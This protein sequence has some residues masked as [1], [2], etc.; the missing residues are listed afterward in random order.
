MRKIFCHSPALLEMYYK[1]FERDASKFFRAS[2]ITLEHMD[3][4]FT[5]KGE[6][7]KVIGQVDFKE[8]VCKNVESGSIY[9]IDRI[10]VQRALIGETNIDFT[11]KRNLKPLA[12]A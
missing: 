12:K 8:M 1:E 11:K 7:W 9:A 4:E 10:E 5:I 6:K 3:T 2:K